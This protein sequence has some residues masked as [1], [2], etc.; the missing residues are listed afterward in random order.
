[1]EN[2]PENRRLLITCGVLVGVMCIC[3]SLISVGYAALILGD[4]NL[5]PI[6]LEAT[7]TP[8]DNDTQTNDLQPTPSIMLTPTLHTSDQ[9]PPEIS[10][11]MDLIH[12]QVS[13]MR[14]LSPTGP[15]T[16]LLLTRE[17][18]RQRLIEDFNA[19]YSPEEAQE[20]AIILSAFGLLEQ[21]F[22]L[23]HFFLD[24][25]TEQISGFY[26]T[27]TKEMYV[28]LDDEFG[29]MQKLTYAHEY[30]HALQDQH[31]DIR[32]DLKYNEEDC[33][34]DSER[35]AAVQALLEG[36]ASLTELHWFSVHATL[37]DFSD[38]EEYFQG[39]ESPIFDR[40]PAF[41]QADIL[42]PYTNGQTFVEYFHQSG[43][44]ETVNQLYLDVPVSTKQILYPETYPNVTPVPVA[45]PDLIHS[46]GEGWS[47]LDQGVLGEWYTF[48]ILA[49]GHDTSVRLS[50]TQAQSAVNGWAGDGFT[51]YY[52]DQNDTVA[53]VLK[54]E[55]E[56]ETEAIEFTESFIEF[57]TAR[58]GQ[59][60]INPINIHAWETD[61]S[62]TLFHTAENTTLWIFA[63]NEE[64]V[65][66]IWE[67]LP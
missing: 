55:W 59:S 34:D 62:Y 57:T 27:K 64:I 20:D 41:I 15:L 33:E 61:Q 52:H 12:E 29:V 36:D 5:F 58:Y 9:I 50:E 17:E 16:R 56:N 2:K 32:D 3:I 44:W 43:G 7:Q 35:C 47:A 24:L 8:I 39:Y 51:V 14:G 21:S 18:L 53:M 38:L 4:G 1:M 42:F 46:L 40:A 49:H 22:D 28:V 63:S 19:D 23:Y 60:N 37:Q 31:F 13:E 48:L 67:T 26:D 54:T 65:Q 10:Q 25:Y 45:L 6:N 66:T 11:Q 30:V